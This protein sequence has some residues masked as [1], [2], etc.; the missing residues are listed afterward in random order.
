MLDE[1]LSLWILRGDLD[2][3]RDSIGNSTP[4]DVDWNDWSEVAEPYFNPIDPANLF[5]GQLL[6]PNPDS[7]SVYG[8]ACIMSSFR[9]MGQDGA[10]YGRAVDLAKRAR[11][12]LRPGLD[13]IDGDELRGRVCEAEL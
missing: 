13:W 2:P 5:D 9:N 7:P 12:P 6:T 11:H 10:D 4:A 8:V 1:D 3:I